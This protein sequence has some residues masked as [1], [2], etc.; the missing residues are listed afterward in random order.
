[1]L[2]AY[3]AVAIVAVGVAGWWYWPWR[4]K[5]VVP[6]PPPSATAR[7]VVLAYLH[8]LDA[9][10]SATAYAVSAPDYKSSAGSWLDSTARIS[11]IWVGKLQ[12]APKSQERYYVPVTFWYYSHWWKQDDSFPNGWHQW[13]YVLTRSHGRFLIVDEGVG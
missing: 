2:V 11:Q 3:F 7:Q 1:V 12:Y 10:D 13:G 4:E 9:H 5:Y 6:A 8:A